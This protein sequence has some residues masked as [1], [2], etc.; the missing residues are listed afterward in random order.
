MREPAW[1]QLCLA[2]LLG[3]LVTCSGGTSTVIAT[4]GL[5]GLNPD[6]TLVLVNGK[7]RHSSALVNVNGS[8]GRGSVSVDFNAFP[9]SAVERQT[10]KAWPPSE[11]I[12]PRA[13]SA[14]PPEDDQ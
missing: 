4:G 13:K 5:R 7:R 11:Y 10:T 14:W 1:S 9:S 6:Q 8:I 2:P 3:A 12:A